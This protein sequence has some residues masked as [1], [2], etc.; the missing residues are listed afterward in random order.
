MSEVVAIPHDGGRVFPHFGQA[1][2]FKIYTI[3]SGRVMDS[4]V[5]ATTDVQNGELA[6]W[7][8]QRGVTR[9][10][11]GGIGPGSL[12]E[13]AV[14]GIAALAGVEGSADVAI[15]DWLAGRLKPVAGATCGGSCSAGGC[16]GH[17]HGGCSC[18]EKP[19]MSSTE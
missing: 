10:I 8:L 5:V 14:P 4:E 3:E 7:L 15:E 11:C 18:G 19:R 9:V 2:E 16:A 1:K 13:L 12:G 17:C 6:L